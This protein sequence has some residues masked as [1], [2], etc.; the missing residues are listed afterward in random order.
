MFSP[1]VIMSDSTGF[2]PELY[3][4]QLKGTLKAFDVSASNAVVTDK[5]TVR[6][7]CYTN[8]MLVILSCEVGELILG[9]IA[10]IVVKEPTMVLLVL[11]Q[12]RA[13]LDPDL[14]VYEVD[15]DG[16]TFLCK[17]LDECLDYIPLKTLP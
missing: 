2:Y 4:S 9:L 13:C 6:G 11:R 12:K 1:E 5:I 7:T 10:C 16:G 8:D 3:D 15:S 14:G 17:R